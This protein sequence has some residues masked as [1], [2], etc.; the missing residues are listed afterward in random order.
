ME[1]KKNRELRNR[2]TK[3]YPTDFFKKCR[4]TIQWRKYMAFSINGA[5]AIGHQWK[6]MNLDL[7]LT[8]YTK[9]H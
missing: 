5:G 4:K 9:S 2:S 7:S 6:I 3:T 1:I 8:P